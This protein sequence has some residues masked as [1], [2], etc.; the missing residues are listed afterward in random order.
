MLVPI[1]VA[2]GE[3]APVKVPSVL[4]VLTEAL[5][6]VGSVAPA[7]H[8]NVFPLAIVAIKTSP[9]VSKDQSPGSRV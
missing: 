5:L 7:F 8:V 2:K 6:D 3:L 1:K 4:G 9:N